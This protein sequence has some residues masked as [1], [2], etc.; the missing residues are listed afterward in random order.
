M[1]YDSN[2][3]DYYDTYKSTH[4]KESKKQKFSKFI[5]FFIAFVLLF[6]SFFYLY[7]YFNPVITK[8]SVSSTTPPKVKERLII[9]EEHLPQSIQLQEEKPLTASINQADIALIVQTVMLQMQKKS[10]KSLET[11]LKE[12]EHKSFKHESLEKTN[13]YNKIILSNKQSNDVQNSSLVELSSH[14]QALT[15]S[16]DNSSSTYN[17]SIRK[18][19]HFRERE[20][21]I[22]VV[23]S[24]DT[25]S[26]IAKRAYGNY[27][28]YPKI[29]E[30]NPEII[31]NPDEIFV[32]QRLRIPS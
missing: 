32:G 16:S 15:T 31:Q 6:L 19:I 22:I 26:K 2:S 11:Q 25:L 3:Q 30:A 17:K 9:K 28:A 29:F 7:Q 14:L 12:V 24:G 20:M 1:Y 18:E 27:D 10:E 21:R 4:L 5:L 8:E 13:H 23:Q